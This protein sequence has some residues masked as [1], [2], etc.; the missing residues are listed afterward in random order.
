MMDEQFPHTGSKPLAGTCL[1]DWQ[2]QD[3]PYVVAEVCA[4]C[5]LFRYKP[6]STADWEYRAPIPVGGM[7][8]SK[9]DV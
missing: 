8:P 1:H 7:R 4:I 2:G 5:K 3:S 9:P 6:S